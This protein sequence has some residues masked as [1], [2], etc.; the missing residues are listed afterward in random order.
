M[1]SSQ[2][3]PTARSSAHHGG[4]GD[5]ARRPK[6][7]ALGC[8]GALHRRWGRLRHEPLRAQHRRLLLP[9]GK[10]WRADGGFTGAWGASARI[11]GRPQVVARG[12]AG[13]RRCATLR[14]CWPPIA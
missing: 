3:L 4:A 1:R 5:A 10:S 13:G 7:L 8:P 11:L 14:T 6:G 2:H 12:K 9:R